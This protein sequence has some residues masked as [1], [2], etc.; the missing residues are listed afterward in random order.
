MRYLIYRIGFYVRSLCVCEARAAIALA[1]QLWI[2]IRQTK[3][4]SS[5]I[6]SKYQL[7]K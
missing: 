7:S 6:S 5:R 4:N 3:A 2:D 1:T